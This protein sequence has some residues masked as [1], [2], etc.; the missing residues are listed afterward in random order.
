[1]QFTGKVH[2]GGGNIP[3]GAQSVGFSLS[4]G[5]VHKIIPQPLDGSGIWGYLDIESVSPD[6]SIERV[7]MTT[8]SNTIFGA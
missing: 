6:F 4:G 5:E 7:H 2:S 1:V 3:G 8:H